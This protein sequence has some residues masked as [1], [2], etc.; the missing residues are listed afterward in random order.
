MHQTY[1]N[2]VWDVPR[3][4]AGLAENGITTITAAVLGDRV[5][6]DTAAGLGGV[7]GLGKI[8]GLDKIA[9]RGKFAYTYF[10]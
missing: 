2:L 4:S 9:G 8:A 7:V 1:G 3:C 5:V 10:Y 6:P